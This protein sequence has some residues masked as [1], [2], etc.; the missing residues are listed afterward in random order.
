MKRLLDTHALLWFQSDD[1]LGKLHLAAPLETLD[2]VEL[3]ADDI[4][5]LPL[6]TRHIVPLTTMPL[7]HKDPFDR[8]IAAA[9]LVD[10]LMLVSNDAIVDLYQVT[11]LW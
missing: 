10:Q 4:F 8:P 3:T 7:H 5:L 9:A 1:R 2:P 6:E 11:R